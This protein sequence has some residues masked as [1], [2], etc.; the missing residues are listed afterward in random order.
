MSCMSDTKL[1]NLLSSRR[2]HNKPARREHVISLT[3]AAMVLI[4]C[5]LLQLRLGQLDTFREM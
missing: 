4:A 3:D 1:L 5:A 2:M